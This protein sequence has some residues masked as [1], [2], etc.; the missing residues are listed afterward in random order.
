MAGG[1]QAAPPARREIVRRVLLRRNIAIDMETAQLVAAVHA[2]LQPAVP[3]RSPHRRHVSPG[4]V[5]RQYST[6]TDL[7]AWT[8][9][10]QPDGISRGKERHDVYADRSWYTFTR[11]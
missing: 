4:A 3:F 1:P 8:F 7:A 11:L 5:T 6:A 2:S 10:Y 9:L